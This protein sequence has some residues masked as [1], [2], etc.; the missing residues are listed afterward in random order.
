M[1]ANPT[2]TNCFFRTLAEALKRFNTWTE[3]PEASTLHPSL[4]SPVLQAGIVSDT[5]RAVDFLTKEWFNTK[6]VDG[7]L[8][9]SRVLG[10]VPDAEIIKK[11]IIPFNFNT[12]PRDNNA[13][14]MHFLGVNLA[15][16]PWG[17]HSQWQYMKENWAACLD[18]LS[19]PIVLD[20]FIR[21]TL[22][23]FV[24]DADVA[25]VTA[26]FQDKDVSSYNRTL[27]TAK[28]KSSARAAYK[29]RDAVAIKEWLA[30]NGY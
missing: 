19:N 28:D 11:D 13:A 5:A 1:N 12:S 30:A 21:S 7:K 10:F 27:E 20:R 14:D 22:S 24:E 15:D 17:R 26:F 23:T 8:V 18:K 2:A 3:N 25:D 9:I 16:N 29:K 4:L 6:S